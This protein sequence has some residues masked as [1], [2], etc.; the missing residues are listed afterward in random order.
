[1]NSNADPAR[2]AGSG[3]A[4]LF[5]RLAELVYKSDSY[6]EISR[7]LCDAAPRLVPGCDHASLMLGQ[8]HR[9]RTAAASDDVAHRI[10]ELERDLRTGPCVDAITDEA[11]Q[12]DPDLTRES[13]WPELAERVLAETTVRGVTAFR[14]MVADSK[15]GALNLFSDTPGAFT[16]ETASEGAVLAAFAAV[17]LTAGEQREEAR[18]LREGL[19]SN[20]EIGKAVGLLMAGHKVNSAE[21]FGILRK[22]SQDMNLKIGVVA[23]E[24]V[25]YHE[26]R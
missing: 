11:F 20:R 2:G 21:A 15:V 19:H 22:A 16:P 10:D 18:T 1:M 4:E 25:Q 3:T 6:E 17:M 14:M 7:A 24:I 12:L 26:N 8:E 23:E 13:Q 9:Y 5:G